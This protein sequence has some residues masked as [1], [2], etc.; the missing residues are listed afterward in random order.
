MRY[1]ADSIRLHRLECL[2]TLGESV[3]PGISSGYT[4]SSMK[5]GCSNRGI[6]RPEAVSDGPETLFLQ[7]NVFPGGELEHLGDIIRD[8]EDAGFEVDQMKDVRK[9]YGLTC[10]A[11]VDRLQNKQEICR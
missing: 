1:R 2:S 3:C 7:R 6:V 4:L 11:W 5:M 9:D 8:A 10:K